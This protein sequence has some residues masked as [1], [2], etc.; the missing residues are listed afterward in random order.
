MNY[1]DI[2]KELDIK[3]VFGISEAQRKEL[4][5]EVKRKRREAKRKPE[6]H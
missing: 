1:P 6:G 3:L 5:A 4:E 2:D